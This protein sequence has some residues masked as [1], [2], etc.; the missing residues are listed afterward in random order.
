MTDSL[1]PAPG[2]GIDPP[3]TF[4]V[5]RGV[6]A[7]VLAVTMVFLPGCEPGDPTASARVGSGASR[8]ETEADPTERESPGSESSPVPAGSRATTVF[9]T[10]EPR[11]EAGLDLDGER[12]RE[13][14]G[15]DREEL[16]IRIASIFPAYGRFA[17]SGIESHRG[18]E[19]AAEARRARG[20]V[21]GRELEILFYRTRSD[22][23]DVLE[24]AIDAWESGALAIIGSNASTLSNALRDLVQTRGIPMVS[25]V[26]TVPDLTW[27]PETGRNH[28]YVFRVCHNDR[29]M[30]RFLAECARMDLGARRAAVLFDVSRR[31]SVHLADAFI[32]AFE[33]PSS[34]GG[35][36][37]TNDFTG[38]TAANDATS[39]V[40]RHFYA[41]LETDFRRQLRAIDR[42]DP[43]VLFL[44][45]SFVDA[46]L[47][48]TQAHDLGLRATLL[49]GDSWSNRLLFKRGG[50][51]GAAY[52]ADHWFKRKEKESAFVALYEDRYGEE[53]NG[54]RAAL[55]YDA[56]N[57]TLR[58]LENLGPVS[59]R[60]LTERIQHTRARL[61][62]L[63]ALV[64]LEGVTGPLT[65]DEHGD[66]P[67]AGVIIK[68]E[69]GERSLYKDFSSVSE[70]SE[71]SGEQGPAE[72]G[73]DAEPVVP[74][75]AGGER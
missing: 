22:R 4:E 62:G 44:P 3:I 61:A 2:A 15:P 69:D 66:P 74:E 21:A 50:P 49:G 16:P 7:L 59:D 17:L 55:A 35:T 5:T 30:G 56:L 25:N 54:A 14:G 1:G 47:I 24:A 45:A 20:R 60:A 43:D 39:A 31:Y 73:P 53:P 41:P 26:S 37:A 11:P 36:G 68:I 9:S 23:F 42:F 75:S 71:S 12:S 63:L 34:L 67:Q 70:D 58:A 6:P 52:H 72:A 38:A 27:N 48:A 19:M 32:Q 18:V 51:S 29:T 13:P 65:F 28:E 46:S 8:V 10:S 33:D 57:V 40:E 64:N